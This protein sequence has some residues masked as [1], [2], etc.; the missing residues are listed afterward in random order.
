MKR[1]SADIVRILDDR[2]MPGMEKLS[3]LPLLVAIRS[4]LAVTMPLVL[5]GS[6]AVLLN[7]FPLPAYRTF[8]EQV[9]GPDWRFYGGVLWSS[10]FAVMS[11]TMQFSVGS[12]VAAQYNTANPGG[13]VNPL[14]AGLV[15]FATLLSL[16]SL[17]TGALS[18]KW[19]GVAGLFVAMLVAVTSVKLFLFLFSIKKLRLHLPGGTPD[20]AIPDM[21]NSLLPGTLTV[22]IFSGAG[23]LLHAVFGTTVH[24]AVQTLLRTPF[25]IMGDSVR[26]GI[27][28]I[29]S[30]QTLWF[31]GIHGANVLDPITHDIYG[32][33]MAA[34]ELAASLGQPLPHVMT[35]T[36]MDV[37]V[38]MGGAGTSISLA[39]A[40]LL[41]GGTGSQRRLAAISFV[42]G[43][44]NLNEILLFGLPVILNPV[45]LI[46]FILTPLLLGIVSY[47]AVAWGLVPGTSANVEWTTPVL[48]NAYLAT[49]SFKAVLLQIVNLGIGVGMYAPFVLISNRINSRRVD[50]AFRALTEA[51]SVSVFTAPSSNTLERTDE[52]GLLARTL[53]TDLERDFRDKKNMFLE[54]QPQISAL[55]GAVV[56]VESLIRWRHPY[57]G[58]VPAPVVITLA[59]ESGLIKDLGMR[60]FERACKVRK[61]WQ[62]A[63][64]ENL[65]MAVNVS[66]AQLDD[67]LINQ[68]VAV[69][70]AH[71]IMPD[72]VELEIAESSLLDARTP[73]SQCLA[74]L[75]ALG[76]RI[77]ID[78]FGMG[79]SSLKYLKQFPVSTVKIDGTITR[80]VTTNPICSDIVSSITRLCRARSMNC[81]AEFVESDAQAAILRTLGVDTLQGYKF[82]RFLGAKECL[83]FIQETNARA[84]RPGDQAM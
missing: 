56:G 22:L 2:L 59:E 71:E 83:A 20:F 48:L 81:V 80:E 77:A 11:L 31:V 41:F 61:Q 64:V 70:R 84:A 29:F 75:H 63:G 3:N 67:S 60:V 15:S 25:D 6:L 5:L 46:P 62:D 72:L 8:M 54:F 45:M 36:F 7:S 12:H 18:T 50:R 65:I 69:M 58:L 82:S 43:I 51:V 44:F 27:F 13:T 4:S 19:M 35:K 28:Y 17:E 76:L 49:G 9:F 52:I 1:L 79:H 14:I 38:F 21:F 26:R 53:L 78:D 40:L 24:E 42:P 23:L 55:T 16:I 39:L 57:H 37:F 68:V 10:T 73:Q 32:A 30:L 33:A 74:K 66:S 47:G 34:N